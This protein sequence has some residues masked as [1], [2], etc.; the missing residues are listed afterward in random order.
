MRYHF[1]TLDDDFESLGWSERKA[2]LCPDG[3]RPLW[4]YLLT[5]GFTFGYHQRVLGISNITLARHLAIAK[6]QQSID[7]T[8]ADAVYDNL[9]SITA[10][11][12]LIMALRRG[13]AHLPHWSRMAICEYLERLGA[14]YKVARLFECSATTV[15]NVVKLGLGSYDVLSA[16]RRLASQQVHPPGKWRTR[17]GVGASASPD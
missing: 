3:F 5:P 4:I 1:G 17:G 7:P 13:T 2:K 10:E 9:S 11:D 14:A 16:E 8:L 12:G 6:Q 15:T